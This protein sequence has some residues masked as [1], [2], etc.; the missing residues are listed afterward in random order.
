MFA[1]NHAEPYRADSAR[2]PIRLTDPVGQP[3]RV[4]FVMHFMHMAGAEVLVREIIHRLHGLIEPTVIC[5]DTVDQIGEEL[6]AEGVRC[7]MAQPQARTRLLRGPANCGVDSRAPYPSASCAPIHALLLRGAG[8]S[9]FAWSLSAHSDGTWQALSGRRVAASKSSEPARAESACQRHQLVQCVWRQRSLPNRRF[10]RSPNRGDRQRHR[11]GAYAVAGDRD[12]LRSRLGLRADRQYVTCVARFHPVKD[13]VTLLRAF[14]GVADVRQDVDLLL[15][16][17]GPMQPNIERL[18]VELQIV[19]RVRFLGVHSDVPGLLSA[20]DVFALTSVT[21]SAS[22]TLMEAMATGIPIVATNVGGNP[23]FVRNEIDGL[24]FPRGDWMAGTRAMLRVL[25]DP[26]LALK[27]ALPLASKRLHASISISRSSGTS[28]FTVGWLD[29]GVRSERSRSGE[30]ICPNARQRCGDA[31]SPRSCAQSA[32]ARNWPGARRFDSMHQ[33][34]AGDIRTVHSAGVSRMDDCGVSS[35]GHHLV[36]RDP[37]QVVGAN[38]RQLLRR[39][40]LHPRFRHDR[41]R[42]PDR[43]G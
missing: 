22:L 35:V 27:L 39:P 37:V 40:P 19:D 32:V 30:S 41:T 7:G 14:A 38:S 21:E 18:A 17:K 2:N 13:H 24:L 31:I 42:C 33:P 9:P 15:A 5:L 11:S 26:V 20:S 28:R 12:R 25:D 23:E 8:Q 43:N 3:I 10:S 36:W 34:V 6:R 1:A 16:G 4:G 29:V